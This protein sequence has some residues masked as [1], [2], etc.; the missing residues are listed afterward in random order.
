MHVIETKQPARADDHREC[1]TY[2]L[3]N[4]FPNFPLLPEDASKTRVTLTLESN[5]LIIR[6]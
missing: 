4:I 1:Y 3:G 5:R 6:K 2:D